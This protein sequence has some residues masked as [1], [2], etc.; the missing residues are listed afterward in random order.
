MKTNLA[1]IDT[2]SNAVVEQPRVTPSVSIV[3]GFRVAAPARENETWANERASYKNSARE[4]RERLAAHG[5]TPLAVLPTTWWREMVSTKGLFD[6]QPDPAGRVRVGVE[7]EAKLADRARY[8]VMMISLIAGGLTAASAMF[9][10]TF[11]HPVLYVPYFFAMAFAVF[12]MFGILHSEREGNLVNQFMS[13]SCASLYVL[14]S[15]G[16]EKA[17]HRLLRASGNDRRATNVSIRLPEPPQ[18]VAE[19]LLKATRTGYTLNVAAEP[20]AV[21]FAKSPASII[22][23]RMRKESS[24]R[25]A[26]RARLRALDPIIYVEH[27][28][29]TAIIAQFGEFPMEKELIETIVARQQHIR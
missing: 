5:I 17:M 25:E 1:H 26:E 19:T 11:A 14:F 3:A 24:E 2:F 20:G 21:G 13:W 8:G 16:R 27:G 23:E 29:A 7:E 15:G 28:S 22:A 4:V 18:D 10:P 12:V 9:M 6:L